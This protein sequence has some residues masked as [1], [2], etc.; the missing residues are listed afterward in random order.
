MRVNTYFGLFAP[1][2][3]AEGDSTAAAAARKCSD[4]REQRRRR[5]ALARR[6]QARG[7]RDAGG[8]GSA[9][10]RRRDRNSGSAFL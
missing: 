8:T 7:R 5:S 2:D 9:L 1:A 6:H 10:T 3:P 4:G